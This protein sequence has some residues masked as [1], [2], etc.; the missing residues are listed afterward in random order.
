MA[1]VAL[2]RADAKSGRLPPLCLYCG[3]PADGR[4]FKVL[5]RIPPWAF[6][7]CLVL[8]PFGILIVNYLTKRA[9]IRAPLCPEHQGHWRWR[10]WTIW[11]SFAAVLVL[12]GL[13]TMFWI[14]T[15]NDGSRP[16]QAL[17]QFTFMMHLLLIVAWVTLALLVSFSAIRATRV[18]R[19]TIVLTNVSALFAA[20]LSEGSESDPTIA[21]GPNDPPGADASGS[22]AAS[23]NPPT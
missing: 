3:A 12:E 19:E 10:S 4:I 1:S 17:A 13:L 15:P 11:G 5:C 6:P 2:N 20:E 8:P 18:T 7:L 22:S 9:S 21:R 16:Y 14:F 23:R